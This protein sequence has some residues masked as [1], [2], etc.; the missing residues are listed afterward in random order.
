LDLTAQILAF[1]KDSQFRQTLVGDCK[2][3]TG[4]APVIHEG[5]DELCSMVEMLQQ[6]EVVIL[7]GLGAEVIP[8]QYLKRLSTPGIVIKNL[9]YIGGHPPEV[10]LK[11]FPASGYNAM[12]TYLREVLAAS[13]NYRLAWSAMPLQ[14]IGHFKKVPFDLYVKISDEKFVKRIPAHEEVDPKVLREYQ[15][16][17]INEFYFHKEHNRDFSQMLINNMINRL[18]GN[19]H[20]LDEELEARSEVFKTVKGIV[21]DLG[22]PAKVVEVCDSMIESIT[23]EVLLDS[24]LGEY[25]DRLKNNPN[26]EIQ[27][28]F[29]ELTCLIGGL[30]IT[31]METRKVQEKLRSFIFAAL[32]CDMT[33]A[34]TELIFCFNAEAFDK[35]THFQRKAV[36]F[37][38]LKAEEL[39]TKYKN[40]PAEA[41]LIIRHHHGSLEG[42]GFP[43]KKTSLIH[44]L[45]KCLIIGQELAHG[46]LTNQQVSSLEIL[47]RMVQNKKG[48]SLQNLVEQ[49]E[50]ILR[51]GP[52][53]DKAA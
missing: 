20:S 53:A 41:G 7:H 16:R 29:I 34:D 28:K 40:A 47:K 30:L 9:I 50:F 25:L 48:T 26:L 46:I 32:F 8:A 24:Q 52:K 12:S 21:L 10:P 35:L 44:P 27:H 15:Q 4:L 6:V 42:I 37:H 2:A 22:I 3:L 33:L 23:D 19:Y 45:A 13:Q 14:A 43:E 31:N 51:V 39:I 17:G 1:T 5:I 38:A 11:S 36:Q 18:E 49:L